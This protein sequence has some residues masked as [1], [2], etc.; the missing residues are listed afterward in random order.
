ML[1]SKGSTPCQRVIL[2]DGLES[3]L[4]VRR[5][6]SLRQPYATLKL[7]CILLLSSA[8]VES[9]TA[10]DTQDHPEAHP[11]ALGYGIYNTQTRELIRTLR[12][13]EAINLAV[14]GPDIT[15]CA[16]VSENT[17]SFL[18][19]LRNNDL[20][21]QRVNVVNSPPFCIQDEPNSDY[22]PMT[23]DL[24][25]YSI[26]GIPYSKPFQGGSSGARLTVS[27]GLIDAD[28]APT[29]S[30]STLAQS[31]DT[32]LISNEANEAED[33]GNAKP[34][35]P[36]LEVKRE[37]LPKT[38]HQ[39][40]QA[41]VEI[42]QINQNNKT[43]PV[44]IVAGTVGAMTLCLLGFIVFKACKKRRQE[45]ESSDKE[46]EWGKAVRMNS[47]SHVPSEDDEKGPSEKGKYNRASSKKMD[48]FAAPAPHFILAGHEKK[49]STSTSSF[50]QHQRNPSEL[51][52]S[53]NTK[54]KSDER[55][56]NSKKGWN[57][58]PKEEEDDEE[59]ASQQ[60]V[61]QPTQEKVEQIEL[62]GQEEDDGDNLMKKELKLM[63]YL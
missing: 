1:S 10:T 26:I 56:R 6:M 4:Q 12:S 34:T 44:A 14:D 18:F 30:P 17:L 43:L 36:E 13:G 58:L 15:I 22:Q 54:N 35:S 49:N 7:C 50:F 29:N 37:T 31:I 3:Q 39:F 20:D 59:E 38:D 57:A 32:Q 53:E 23:R 52:G 25:E 60:S 16:L 48:K 40:H 45:A 21:V 61:A 46:R 41:A 19:S 42:S 2:G 27:F 51:D 9:V 11:V 24:G 47:I 5:A 33:E 62:A 63:N 55:I 8:I 28:P